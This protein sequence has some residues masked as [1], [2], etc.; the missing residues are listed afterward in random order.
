MKAATV[1]NDTNKRPV[2][3]R[4]TRRRFMQAG[5]VAGSQ[6]VVRPA[7]AQAAGSSLEGYTSAPSV[8]VGGT[9]DFFLRDPRAQGTGTTAYPLTFTRIGFPDAT[10]LIT[11]VPLGNQVVPSDATT[12]GCRWVRSYQLVVPST[13]KS[14]L[15]FA[16]VGSGSTACTVPFVVR[17]VGST[18]G[19]NRLVQIQVSTAQAY[20]PYGG[21]SLY[22]YNSSS[23][24]RASKVSF[25]R[26]FSEAFNSSFDVYAQYLVRWL[27]KNNLAADFCTDVD[28]AAN[29]ALLDPYQLFIDV[30]HDE[31][32]TLGRRQAMDAFVARGGNA[33]YLG[34]NTAWFQSR[35]E[36][37]N[38]G[39]NRTLVCYKNAAADPITDP[40]QK[41]V[42]FVSLVPPNPENKTTGLG[43]LTG[44]SW[45]GPQ[46][47]PNTPAVVM[48]SEHWAFAGTGLAGGAGFGG[49]FIG[50]ECD[51]TYFTRGT[52]QRPYPTGADGAPA[53]LRILAMADGSTWDAQSLA[54]GGTGEQS[55]YSMMAV[56][57]RGGGAGT[58]FNAGTVEWAYALIP[59]LNGQAPTPHS[60]I[61][62]N[63][64][65]QL[66]QPW[67]ETA[68]VRQFRKPLS[69]FLSNCY[70]G[71]ETAPPGGS[72]M[73]L[74]G[75]VFRAFPTAVAG[76][77][78][79]YRY[80][81]AT[82]GSTGTRY[83]YSLSNTLDVAGSYWVLEGTA[84]N[85]WSAARS[86][87]L[88]VY[89]HFIINTA[90][91]E[92]SCL[93]SL[94][95]TPPAGWSAGAIVFYAPSDGA[96]AP[97]PA[98]GFSLTPASG[99]LA[100]V[101]GQAVSTVITIG[102]LNG[103]SGSVNFSASGLPAGVTASFTPAS[104]TT[105][106]TLVLTSS[107][108]AATGSFQV[109]VTGTSPPT[110]SAAAATASLSLTLAI[111]APSAS[112]TVIV[113][114]SAT[115]AGGIG[116]QMDLRVNGVLIAS[117][118]VSS[119]T[120][121]D[122][123]F[124]TPAIQ[125]GDLIDVV[126]TNDALINGEDRNLYIESVTARGVVLSSTAAGVKIDKGT[127]A[128]AFDGKSVVAA[129]SYGGWIPWN[130]ALR[131]VA[132]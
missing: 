96:A 105:S 35:L 74:D 92:L 51:S 117:S 109:L 130:G 104:A 119:T 56:F 125:V 61:T 50:Y 43:Y 59:E 111:S 34:A 118:L 15:Y 60:R 29:S 108:T 110:P 53:T 37:G 124:T 31:Y 123:V 70:Y 84:F 122:M 23:G 100:A 9:L 39:A 116:A 3:S 71:T 86:D 102:P 36:S 62:L 48:R 80:R 115:L 22:D 30:G 63:V 66:S 47:R 76:S 91:Q 78:P 38:A 72:G 1:K 93:Y 112:G 82:P 40:A 75:W 94:Q 54:L 46:T 4:L 13:W 103:F 68:D 27:A 32:W 11:S 97:A 14:G 113:R 19:V 95:A 17:A 69:G 131:L 10:T 33:A 127:G 55:G 12:N 52:D 79:V 21:K 49:Q 126:F 101:Q 18:P 8:A 107:A 58:V 85:A 6:A 99:S 128:A 88:A 67:T 77:A 83:R 2:A 90:L 57:S 16:F 26:P 120:V 73:A 65:N 5:A 24:V 64:I 89:E 81:S 42:N 132:K 106:T 20:N 129:S 44:C 121:Q 41:T 28:I 45:T 87:A 114:G 98:P 25:D 7:T